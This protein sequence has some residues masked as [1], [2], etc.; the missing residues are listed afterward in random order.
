M[1]PVGR[2]TA[3]ERVLFR[4][5]ELD[6]A[7]YLGF[8]DVS[9]AE[10]TEVLGYLWAADVPARLEFY[11]AW[12]E[13]ARKLGVANVSPLG[14]AAPLLDWLEGPLDTEGGRRAAFTAGEHERL[15]GWLGELVG[16]ERWTREEAEAELDRLT[17]PA[18]FPWREPRTPG[19]IRCYARW[20]ELSPTP[21]L[22]AKI[23][24]VRKMERL[25]VPGSLF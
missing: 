6:F 15:L 16:P 22:A 25:I 7:E 10:A 24:L 1:T 8:V 11:W 14:S 4:K 9:A 18:L 12:R 17:R 5:L 23:A 21:S 20:L 3:R 13:R 19:R 2:P